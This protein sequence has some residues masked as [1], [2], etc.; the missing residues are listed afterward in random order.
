M[1]FKSHWHK[2]CHSLKKTNV[3]VLY[4]FLFEQHQECNA[5][6]P[7][8]N[9]FLKVLNIPRHLWGGLRGATAATATT[10][11]AAATTYLWNRGYT[12]QSSDCVNR[13]H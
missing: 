8:K 4:I 12:H 1:T 5:S 9:E 6:K 11:T 10:A 13:G 3:C 2:V 7:K